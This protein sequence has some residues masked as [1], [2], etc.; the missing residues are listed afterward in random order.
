VVVEVKT[1]LYTVDASLAPEFVSSL[2]ERRNLLSI[3][4]PSLV[5]Y[6]L[7]Q[8]EP[9][10][11]ALRDATAAALARSGFPLTLLPATPTPPAALGKLVLLPLAIAIPLL[12]RF[13]P[14]PL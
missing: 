7:T 9:R 11:E 10:V 13:T 6:I 14:V 1:A 4:L 3:L 2:P 8:R 12:A 5:F